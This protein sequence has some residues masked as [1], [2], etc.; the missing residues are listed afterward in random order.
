MGIVF[1]PLTLDVL[2][3]TEPVSGLYFSPVRVTIAGSVRCITAECPE[4]SVV[5]KPDGAGEE[6]TQ[7]QFQGCILLYL[8]F[9]FFGLFCCNFV[10]FKSIGKN[11]CILF[12]NWGKNMHFPP[13]FYPP[14]IIFFPN[15]LFGHIF[16]GQT[17]KYTP[18]YS[19][20]LGVVKFQRI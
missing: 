5:L 4:L 10:Y 19:F 2:L 13:F 1:A 14:S 9:I 8:K 7:V 12:T 20:G 11:I 3:K 15:L 6:S 17:E 18:L 16:A